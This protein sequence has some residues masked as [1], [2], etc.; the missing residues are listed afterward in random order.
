M[1]DMML[2]FFKEDRVRN[3]E[4]ASVYFVTNLMINSHV[5][6]IDNNQVTITVKNQMLKCIGYCI[7]KRQ[8][9]WQQGE[10]LLPGKKI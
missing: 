8:M 10:K 7:P 3:M 9:G 5:I 2:L 4:L 1:L 6:S